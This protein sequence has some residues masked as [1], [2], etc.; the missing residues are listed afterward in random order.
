MDETELINHNQQYNRMMQMSSHPNQNPQMQYGQQSNN[1]GGYNN[2]GGYSHPYT[3]QQ[4]L[5][6]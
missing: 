6:A 2:F 5:E 1:T 3:Q 4:L